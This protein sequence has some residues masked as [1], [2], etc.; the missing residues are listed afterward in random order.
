MVERIARDLIEKSITVWLDEWEILIGDSITQ[1]VQQG[2]D[3]VDFVLL[4]LTT[5]S[6]ESGWVEKEWRSQVGLEAERKQVRILPV[7]GD[8][9]ELPLLL[10]DKKCADV[11]IDYRKAVSQLVRAIHEHLGRHTE[12]PGEAL[13]LNSYH[14]PK[15]R[16]RFTYWQAALVTLTL[17]A[18]AG[19]LIYQIKEGEAKVYELDANNITNFYPK[20]S[21]IVPPAESYRIHEVLQPPVP[22][23]SGFELLE[24]K[25]VIDMRD[26]KPF[27]QG[28]EG[29]ISPVTWSRKIRLK[30]IAEAEQVRFD[31]ATEGAGIDAACLSGEDYYLETGIISCDPPQLLLKT[32]QVVVNVAKYKVGEEFE[33]EIQATFWNG[34]SEQDDWTAYKVYAPVKVVQ[35]L[36]LFPEQKVFKWRKLVMYKPG[37]A[38][39]LSPPE[40][41]R[42]VITSPDNRNLY[43][44][45]REP[46]P[47]H[48]Y[49]IQWGW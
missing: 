44:E 49:E 7:R 12:K 25:R 36:L 26:W 21:Q 27:D 33:I 41:Q 3:E 30:K 23:Y 9:C 1:R 28:A 22:D 24:D 37:S 2:L 29:R 45:I 18:L 20:R 11:N 16:G 13:P 32:L 10:S 34:S 39:E 48:I 17:L 5:H 6:V 40:D 35:M 38:A 31:F 42:N 15:R 47:G 46:I 14:Q 19:F 8:A 43:W 4:F